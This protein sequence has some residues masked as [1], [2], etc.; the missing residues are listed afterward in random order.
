MGESVWK[1]DEYIKEI[2]GSEQDM[3]LHIP[4]SGNDI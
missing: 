4:G 2:T 1:K 3:Y